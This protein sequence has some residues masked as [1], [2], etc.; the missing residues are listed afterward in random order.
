MRVWDRSLLVGGLALATL[1]SAPVLAATGPVP[2]TVREWA[3]V[4]RTGEPV[5]TGVPIEPADVGS[6]WALFDGTTEIPLQTTVLPH[7]S[8]PWLLLDFQATLNSGEARSFTLRP[9]APTAAHARPIVIS[10]TSSKITVT[11]GLLRTDLS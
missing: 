6:S 5:T 9:Q 8:C 1:G 7:R 11:T 3:G 2:L 4:A 10:E